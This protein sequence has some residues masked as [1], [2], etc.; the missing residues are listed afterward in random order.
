M[1]D[2][3]VDAEGDAGAMAALLAETVALAESSDSPGTLDDGKESFQEV[4]DSD[5]PDDTNVSLD[6]DDLTWESTD[7]PDG[8]EVVP[9]ADS[10]ETPVALDL[11]AQEE[12]DRERLIAE[13]IA[14]AEADESGTEP[15]PTLAPS[16]GN[17]ETSGSPGAASTPSV[18]FPTR[19]GVPPLPAIGADALAALSAMNRQGVTLPDEL[20][21]D[22]GEATTP[23]DRDRLLAAAL[24]HVEMQD[25]VYRVAAKQ[26]RQSSRWKGAA[27][28]LLFLVAIAVAAQPPDWVVPEAPAT[29]TAADRLDGVRL[30]LL[31]QMQ[32]IE[33][34]RAREGRLPDALTEIAIV[35]PGVRFVKSNNRVYQL[36]AYS[37]DGDPVLYDS[38]APP[39]WFEEV[40][41]RWVP[42]RAGS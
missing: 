34:F 1:I 2:L 4:D 33:V 23:E 20:V 16:D 21:L 30:T 6:A 41:A 26:N 24:A 5:D 18:T 42:T 13:A 37:P 17:A 10:Q 15:E 27:A 3:D 35:L 14:F 38:A 31:L 32:Q 7:A 12:Y 9:P 40:A 28:A 25:A 8:M 19:A 11:D 22:L 29:L 36:V 39:A